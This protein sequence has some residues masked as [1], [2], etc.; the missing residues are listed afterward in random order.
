MLL[1]DDGGAMAIIWHKAIPKEE[2]TKCGVKVLWL[3][4][5]GGYIEGSKLKYFS[6]ITMFRCRWA[7]DFYMWNNSFMDIENYYQL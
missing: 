5:N 1:M 2:W 4:R 3:F 7:R 6:L